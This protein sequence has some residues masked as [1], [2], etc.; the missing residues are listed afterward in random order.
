[1]VRAFA[2]MLLTCSL[3]AQT[4][5]P[6]QRFQKAVITQQRGDNAAALE[7]YRQLLQEHPKVIV[8]RVNLASALVALGRF[9]EAIEQYRAVR[10]MD[11][12]R[13]D[14]ARPGFRL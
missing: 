11:R 5:S 3:L 9:D 10:V 4:E 8:V 1:M 7:I 6:E 2:V 12:K 13:T 14:P